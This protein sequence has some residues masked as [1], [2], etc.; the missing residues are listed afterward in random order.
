MATIEIDANAPNL[1]GI[2]ADL[3][4]DFRLDPADSSPPGRQRFDIHVDARGGERRAAITAHRLL[5]A[6][7]RIAETGELGD[8]RIIHGERWLEEPA[9]T[10]GAQ[11]KPMSAG[12]A[13]ESREG[14]SLRH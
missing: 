4:Y 9:G 1:A 2:L 10:F 14:V 7:A 11:A 13:R 8:F 5:H 6:L 12:S 3:R